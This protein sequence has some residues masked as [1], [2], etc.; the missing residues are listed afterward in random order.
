MRTWRDFAE[1]V[2]YNK[3]NQI[4]YVHAETLKQL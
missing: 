3:E 2:T 1:P 4:P